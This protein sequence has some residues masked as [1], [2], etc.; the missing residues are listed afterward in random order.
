MNSRVFNKLEAIGYWCKIVHVT[1][2]EHM[3]YGIIIP[4]LVDEKKTVEMAINILFKQKIVMNI[5]DDFF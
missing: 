2:N 1:N 3:R 5:Y 4:M